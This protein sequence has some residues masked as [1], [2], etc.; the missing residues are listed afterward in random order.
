MNC[1][2]TCH[3]SD[4]TVR[5]VLMKEHRVIEAVLDSVERMV[6]ADA[7]DEA[8]LRQSLDFFRNFADG[9]HHMKEEEQLFPA[10]EKAGVPREGGPIGCMLSDHEVGR[11]LLRMIDNQLAPAGR[12]DPDARA[13]VRTAAARYVT[14]LRQHIQKEDNVLFVIAENVLSDDQKSAML[15]AFAHQ[16][17][18]PK[19]D[20]KHAHYVNLADTLAHWRFSSETVTA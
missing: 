10:L 16:E 20:G 2:G 4:A 6:Q 13:T 18:A 8:F 11:S 15:Q 9:C 7:F 1:E 19:C 14:M 5:K 17:Q 12:G 3:C